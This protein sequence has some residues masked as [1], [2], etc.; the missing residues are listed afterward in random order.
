MTKHPLVFLAGVRSIFFHESLG[1]ELQD[2]IAAHG[3]V[4]LAPPLPFRSRAL[5]HKA[6]LNWLTAQKTDRFHFVL[7]A[8]TKD[9]FWNLL[10]NYP[11]SSFTVASTD[12]KGHSSAPEPLSYKLHRLF[13]RVLGT[14]ADDYSTTLPDKSTEFFDRFLDR[15]IE[16][17]E[18][19]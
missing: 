8:A 17:A 19:E 3:Y 4:V 1:K 9:E 16:L 2:Y 12:L 6:L 18:N 11:F 15:C 10:K 5:R 7:A 14:R 13:C